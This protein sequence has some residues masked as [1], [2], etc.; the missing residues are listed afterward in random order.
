MSLQAVKSVVEGSDVL[1]GAQNVSA[2]TAGAFT[3]EISVEMLTGLATYA[4]V[5][6]SERRALVRRN[7]RRR[8]RKGG[9]CGYRRSEAH[10][11]RG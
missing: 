1:V 7:G 2:E 5:G 10:R 3:G 4:I 8:G 9:R 6:H 11:V